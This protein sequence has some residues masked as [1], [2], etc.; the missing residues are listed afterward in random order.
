MGTH[1]PSSQG[2]SGMV[3]LEEKMFDMDLSTNP[4]CNVLL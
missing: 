2:V 3:V 1:D 4:E